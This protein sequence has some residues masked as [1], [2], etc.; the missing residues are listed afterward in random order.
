MYGSEKKVIKGSSSLIKSLNRN[1]V[2]DIIRQK[3]GISRCE[4]AREIKL[5]PTT[6]STMVED[7]IGDNLV[8]ETGHRSSI[9]GRRPKGLRHN[10]EARYVIGIEV[11]THGFTA[12]RMNLDG[13]VTEVETIEVDRS[14]DATR[15]LSIVID[16]T[17]KLISQANGNGRLLMV[18][19]GLPGLVDVEKGILVFSPPFNW[20]DVRYKYV[21]EEH[22]KVPVKVDN[23]ERFHALGEMR[24]GAAKGANS[25]VYIEAVEDGIGAGIV[26]DGKIYRG[27]HGSAG[28]IGHTVVIEN[29]PLCKCG[30]KGCLESLI[31]PEVLEREVK[32]RTSEGIGTILGVT[33]VTIERVM[34][35]ARNGDRVAR[36]VLDT[37]IRAMAKTIAD[38]I[39]TLDTSVVVIGGI[40][41][42]ADD[43]S[44]N[45]LKEAIQKDVFNLISNNVKIVKGE[46]GDSGCAM[47]AGA[48]VLHELRENIMGF[49]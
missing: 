24:F 45:M 8:V 47:G 1:L 44:F 35:A 16:M 38:V 3:T 36:E 46:L 13:T 25:A 19:V 26:L 40:F 6:V 22:L 31:Y 14:V 48:Y 30:N 9:V 37:P 41:L 43:F 28:E 49:L 42:K 15:A 33:G 27:V 21:L 17:K 4:I 20:K 10:P 32:A 34:D 7:L 5:S 2:W 39:N 23:V 11:E 29:G 18:G 12:V